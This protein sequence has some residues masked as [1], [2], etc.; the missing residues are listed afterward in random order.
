LCLWLLVLSNSFSQPCRRNFIVIRPW[1]QLC[2]VSSMN[3]VP[4]AHG[5]AHLWLQN[6]GHTWRNVVSGA[7]VPP[8][9][10][11]ATLPGFQ[12]DGSYTVEWWDP[13]QADPNQQIIR[14]ETIV[15][16]TEGRL[17]INVENL[18]RDIAVKINGPGVV[19]T[20]PV[21]SAE[22]GGQTGRPAC[23]AR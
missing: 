11:T 2:V 1:T 6:S 4:I 15:A 12:P 20:P 9:S 21:V 5:R 23:S 22:G 8:Q 7:A 19:N 18:D 3:G 16:D 13:Y 14:T 17:A 10:G